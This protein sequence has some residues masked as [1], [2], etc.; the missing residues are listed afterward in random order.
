MTEP[1]VAGHLASPDEPM[2]RAGSL[3]RLREATL[4]DAAIV[5]ARGRDPAMIGEFNDF[6]LGTPRPLAENLA[7][8]KRMVAPDRGTLLVVRLEDEAVV[9]D[10]SWHSVSYGPTEGSR[11]LN[12]GIALHPEARGHGYGTEAQRLL[13]ELLLDRFEIQRVE[14]STDVDNVAEQRSLEKAGF[15][16]EGVIRRAQSR[17]GT[18]HDLVGYSIVRSDVIPSE[19]PSGP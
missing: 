8:G 5:D 1:D 7:K 16:R 10:V 19:D 12:I 4:E 6:G 13:A 2:G 15:T 9:G 17:A 18:Q 3:V 14:A 11:A